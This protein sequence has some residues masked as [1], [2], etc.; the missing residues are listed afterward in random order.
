MN[1]L[2]EREPAHEFGAPLGEMKGEAAS[3]VLRHEIGGAYSHFRDEGVEIK[4]VVLKAIGDVR[5]ARL[6]EADA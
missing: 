3:P 4:R 6:T 5:L 1:K 2:H